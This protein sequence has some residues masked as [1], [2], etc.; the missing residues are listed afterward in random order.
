MRP[1]QRLEPLACEQISEQN[2][3]FP[4]AFAFC[5]ISPHADLAGAGEEEAERGS[6]QCIEVS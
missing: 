3:P 5:L 6:C 4:D 2:L 1:G